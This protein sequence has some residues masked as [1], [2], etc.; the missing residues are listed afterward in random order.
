M[1]KT[2]NTRSAKSKK[3]VQAKTPVTVAPVTVAPSAAVSLTPAPA[4]EPATMTMP[5]T[6]TTTPPA[7]PSHEAIA[8]R[9][10]EIYLSR[11]GRPGNPL[12]DWF[13]AER[14]LTTRAA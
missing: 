2:R 14:E 13:A 6:V 4:P 10:F 8:R 1:A 11:A 5:M 7:L 9:A 3:S 12:D